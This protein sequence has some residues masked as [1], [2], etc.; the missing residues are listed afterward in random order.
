MPL[1]YIVCFK[2]CWSMNVL[3]YN[4]LQQGF[5][6]L[7]H[8]LILHAVRHY[9]FNGMTL[10]WLRSYLSGRSQRV[11]YGGFLSSPATLMHGV[12]QGSVLGPT[13]FNIFI[14]G[15]LNSLPSNS[16]IAYA[17]DVTLISQGDNGI[18]ASN[19]MQMLLNILCSWSL[20]N[21]LTINTAK[22]F[23]KI[24][25]PKV[26]KYKQ[27]FSLLLRLGNANIIQ[28]NAIKILGIRLTDNLRWD[29]QAKHMQSVVNSMIGVLRRFSSS[30][31]MGAQFKIFNAFLLPRIT[32]CLSVWGDGS[33]T[34]TSKLDHLLLQSI[35]ILLNNSAAE[36]NE[37][38]F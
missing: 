26:A 17:D 7:D 14:N 3:S 5:D 38:V 31:N 28:S 20:D 23:S 19:N 8:D 1:K 22:C 37:S 9:G 18:N 4:R 27:P 35:R 21:K 6:T 15:L 29:I 2:D 25:S 16:S 11:K 32:Y 30:L 36:L 34:A 10:N 33:A 24:A 12:P 13:I